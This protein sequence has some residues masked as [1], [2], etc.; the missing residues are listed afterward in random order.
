MTANIRHVVTEYANQAR[1]RVEWLKQDIELGSVCPNRKRAKSGESWQRLN[2][3][4]AELPLAI[5][6]L[7][8]ADAAVAELESL[9]LTQQAAD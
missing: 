1:E 3:T 8:V 2:E 6:R 9:E 5:A 4:T 7:E